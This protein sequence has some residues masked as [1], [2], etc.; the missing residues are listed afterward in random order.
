MNVPSSEVAKGGQGL[1]NTQ[2][3]ILLIIRIHL[4]NWPS[5]IELLEELVTPSSALVWLLCRRW[6]EEV[7][8]LF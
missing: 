8:I 3:C 5:V 6:H 4:L 1:F 7:G 2:A